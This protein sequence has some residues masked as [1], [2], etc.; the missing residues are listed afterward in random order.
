MPNR[1]MC[2]VLEEMR[3]CY[4]TRNFSYLLGLIEEAQS[5]AERMESSLYDKK[6]YTR[7]QRKIKFLKKQRDKIVDE[8]AEKTGKEQDD[9]LYGD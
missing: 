7:L 4:K 5:L 8:I 6:D 9:I 3:R 1:S 2:Q